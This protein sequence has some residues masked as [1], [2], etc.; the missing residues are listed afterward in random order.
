ML[1]TCLKSSMPSPTS[2]RLQELRQRPITFELDIPFADTGNPR[3]RLDLYLPKKRKSDKVHNRSS[4]GMIAGN[5][6]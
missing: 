6:H 5:H 3:H 1:E 4:F 2:G